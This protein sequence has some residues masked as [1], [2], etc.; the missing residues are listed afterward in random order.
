MA[1]KNVNSSKTQSLYDR[2]ADVHN[3]A[4]KV[5]GYQRSVAKYLRSLD[6][7]LN[8]D[9][10]VLDAGSGTGII[11]LGFHDSGLPF[12]R[13]VDLDLSFKSIEVSREELEKKSRI[14]R[15][16][17]VQANVLAMPFA[18]ET[19]D[20]VLTCGVLEY[21]PLDDG[22]REA[23]RVLK[24]G[25]P[26]VFVPV[27]PSIVGSVLELLY[28]FKIHPLESVRTAAQK[29][30]RILGNHEFPITEPIGWSKTVFLLEKI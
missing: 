18:D 10:L 30:F 23:A 19:F 7:K 14:D 15:T 3:L 27:K 2:I 13:V 26:L 8:E 29:Y 25:A 17:A 24:K 16:D 5:N 4:M 9:S 11:T 28:N 1:A 20:L 12:G 22:L 21:T 6:L